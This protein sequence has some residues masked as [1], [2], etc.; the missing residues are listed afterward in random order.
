MEVRFLSP[1]P[2]A[3]GTAPLGTGE[4]SDAVGGSPQACLV[5][6]VQHGVAELVRGAVEVV[7]AGGGV[8]GVAH[9]DLV[10]DDE[11]A[12]LGSEKQPPEGV[13]VATRGIVEALAAGEGVGTVVVGLPG[14]VGGDWLSLQLADID[15]VEE[16]F[17]LERD[18]AT[19]ESDLRR[20][21]GPAEPGVDTE[22]ERQLLN[23]HPEC[24]RL[25]A[26]LLGERHRD[27]RIAVHALGHVELR[28]GV[29]NED[30]EAHLATLRRPAQHLC[31][32]GRV[33]P[34]VEELGGDTVRVTV[35][36]PAGDV[37]HAVEHAK[38][39]LA[40]SVKIPGF[41]PGKV[42]TPVLVQRL[43]KERIYSEAVDSHI[44]GWFWN[45]AARTRIRP[46]AQP[47]YSFELP[48]GDDQD[49]QF[50]A[51]VAVQPKVELVDW[52]GLE[53]PKPSAEVP[54]ELV[55][56]ELEALRESVAEL[57]P[58]ETRPAREGD[59]LV[60]DLV[61][62]NGD[63]QRDTVV[64]LGAGR[65]VEEVEAAL[66]G[67]SAGETR[68]ATYELAD[69]TSASVE[70]QVKEIKEKLL[71]AV[72]DELARS[73]SEFDTLAELRADIEGRL[74]EQ[75]EAE[76]DNAF[77]ANA[78]DTL[79]QA[80][81]VSPAGPL[82]ESRTRELLT[83]FVRSLERRG[84]NAETY[85]QV[86][87]RTAEQLTQAMAA[88][89]AQSVARELA[90]EAAAERLQIEVSDKEVEN[91]VREQAED[92]DEDA[93][94]LIQ[95]LWQTGRHEDLREDLRLRAA[96]DRIAAEVKPIP[97][98]LAEAREAIWTPDKEKPE[99][100]TKLWTPGSQPSG[101]KETA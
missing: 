72:D 73:A 25:S 29:A 14:P 90:L 88:E 12:P 65:L 66:A 8:E 62:P 4:S 23:L 60:V 71:P 42:P 37:H 53:V 85:L 34:R 86:T 7:G 45:A 47:E 77:R 35:G 46:V 55:D 21:P 89:A 78:V 57:V 17:R 1:A 98:Q 95:E 3:P 11:H 91:L 22:V 49:W 9:R 6:Q 69:E 24:A 83:G 31:S 16:R 36:V 70:I 2:R 56:Q 84:I 50:S 76:I 39:D 64:E 26:S 101:T 79:V 41:R 68:Q 30:E 38:T 13:R 27:P 5:E 59:T 87:G 33:E 81:G 82:V 15:V 96:L 94:E 92:A 61:S 75:L 54:Q 18:P 40:S 63:T 10:A 43:G 67:A 80:S 93:D 74:R 44:S 100:E 51:T 28:L 20:L 99:G 19:L 97:V 32:N 48:T 58:A 52:V